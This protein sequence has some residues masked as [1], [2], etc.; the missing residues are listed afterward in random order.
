MTSACCSVRLGTE[1][2]AGTSGSSS[3]ETTKASESTARSSCPIQRPDGRRKSV[4]RTN[5]RRPSDRC[6]RAVRLPVPLLIGLIFLTACSAGGRGGTSPAAAAPSPAASSSDRACAK[7]AL[8]LDEDG[9]SQAAEAAYKEAPRIYGGNTGT[10]IV[11]SASR[12]TFDRDRGPSVRKQCGKRA[13]TR[14]VVVYLSFPNMP[15]ASLSQGVVFV[16]RFA[17]GYHVWERAH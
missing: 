10:R 8:A 3:T 4:F 14:S 6:N 13:W 5:P 17:D 11:E 9:V 1:A 12:A 15:G 2:V 7:G 16:S